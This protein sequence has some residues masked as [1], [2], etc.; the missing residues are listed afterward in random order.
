MMVG[1]VISLSCHF[2]CLTELKEKPEK[3][4]FLEKQVLKKGNGSFFDLARV[5]L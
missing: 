5:M 3:L 2:E 4:E 1:Q